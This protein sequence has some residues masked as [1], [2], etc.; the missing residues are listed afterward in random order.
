MPQQK[1]YVWLY[2]LEKIT[3]NIIPELS[4]QT[5]DFVFKIIQAN[6]NSL[7]TDDDKRI[8]APK[9][10]S[11]LRT[12]Q[13][14]L[15]S[16]A[17]NSDNSPN[18]DGLCCEAWDDITKQILE[19]CDSETQNICREFVCFIKSR[20]QTDEEYE[21]MPILFCIF[22]KLETTPRV[23]D[24]IKKSKPKRLYIASDG[25]REDKEGEKEKVEFLRDFVLK[26]IDWDCEIKTRFSDKN[27]NCKVGPET[28]IDW[29]FENE[30]MGIILEDDC[31]PS[32]SFF[33]FCS[34]LLIKYKN[35]EKIFLISGCNSGGKLSANSYYFSKFSSIWGWATWKRAWSRHDKKIP[36]IENYKKKYYVESIADSAIENY[37]K[38]LYMK[39]LVVQMNEVVY[40]NFDAWDY[41]WHFSVQLHDGLCIYP[42]CNMITNIGCGVNDAAHTSNK[43]DAGANI[44]AGNFYFPMKHPEKI[45][46]KPMTIEQFV[47]FCNA[48]LEYCGNIAKFNKKESLSLLAVLNKF[49]ALK[50]LNSIN[51]VYDNEKEL[52]KTCFENA[53]L[54]KMITYAV[55]CEIYPKAQKY[56]YM[57]L[58]ETA[59]PNKEHNCLNCKICIMVC[60]SKSVF[61][62]QNAGEEE[63]VIGINEKTCD[64]CFNCVKSCPIVNPK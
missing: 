5:A 11:L 62:A 21:K 42:D 32:Q 43:L 52:I 41:P 61:L 44:P 29:F 23:F 58:C 56:L 34:Q 24:S 20:L 55:S 39:F 49:Q 50:A 3:A 35:E 6:I 12:I 9:F 40:N 54:K 17:V 1:L 4:V 31:L 36:E 27:L 18:S 64:L 15:Q 26:N 51:T 59:F 57:A 28:A 22:N 60:P 53:F 13:P 10:I 7:E 33:R 37:C 25:W 48:Y 14:I 8:F 16:D 2:I 63:Y 47:G 45:E 46:A 19:I 38:N 30:E